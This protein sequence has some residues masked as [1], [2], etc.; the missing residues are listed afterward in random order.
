MARTH[1]LGFPRI[2]FERELKF[3]LEAFWRGDTDET[4]LRETGR[5]LR[6]RH[7]ELQRTAGLDQ[8]AAGDFAFYDTML[9]QTA[10]LGA[11]PAR[12]AFDA[13]ALTLAQYFELARGNARQPAM[14]MTKWF[15]T[16]YHYL[17]PELGPE[18]RF[19]GGTEWLFEEVTEALA[20]APHV[21]PVL[22]GPI[23]FLVLSKSVTAGFDRLQL[24]PALV[25]AYERILG[26]LRA[27]GVE[28]V[29]LDEPALCTDLEPAWL[30]AYDTAY[31]GLA[32]TGLKILLATYFGSAADRA[33]RISRLP[34]HGVHIDLMRDLVRAPQSLDVWQRALP[35]H[36]VLS[37]GVIDGRNVWRTN[38]RKTVSMLRPLHDA[39]GDRLW[40]APSCSLSHVPVSLASEIQLDAEVRPWLAFATEKL[41]EVRVIARALN[42][43]EAAVAEA[44]DQSDA[45][46]RSRT[47]SRR[48]TNA[49]V[50]A[51]VAGVTDRMTERDSPFKARIAKQR[52]ALALP[53][54]PTTTIGSF[55]QV[56]SLRATRAA[57]KRGEIGALDYLQH[58][59]SEIE[60]A[61]RKQEALGLDVLVHGEAERNDMVEYFAEH[62]WGYAITREGWVQS[63]GSRCVK[64]PIIYGDVCRPEPITV[65]TIAYAQS[66]TDK[67]VKG[68][69]TGP[70]TM[71]QWSFVRDD[72][73]RESVAMQIALAIRE[74]VS[75]LEKSGVRVIQIDE[76]ALREG[77]PLRRREWP[78]YLAWAVRAFRLAAAAVRDDTQIH[79]HMCYSEFGDILPAIAA[80][81]ADVITIETSRSKME[82]LEAFHAFSYPNDIG[83]GIYDIHSP[84]VPSIEDMLALLRRAADVIPLER[85]WV[86][87][88]CGL[89]TRGWKETEGALRN[90]VEA[91]RVLRA[92][93]E[94]NAR[95][96]ERSVAT[97]R[98]SQHASPVTHE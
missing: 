41:G 81:D 51:Q 52:A 31:R 66:L 82:L 79:T 55:P 87:P 17:V 1:I 76:P 59:R 18:T 49:H 35:E 44:L 36:M 85:L 57:Y 71:L 30:D 74:E 95:N 33:E 78:A 19:D 32:D 54:L 62:L 42:E 9:S 4:P 91:A 22:I 77:L 50:R 64:P 38:L 63:Y 70:I 21:K 69:L 29:Q 93:V 46:Q 8:I 98:Q 88:D 14:E 80:L 16:N 13:K 72:E 6:T 5:A 58:I 73:A 3:A 15:D 53:L 26:R 34:V 86:N 94:G 65:D 61:V 28:W 68:M 56:Q 25:R 27:L 60:S 84:R 10:L 40:I 39:C 11:V 89:K 97:T 2:G 24:L 37:A 83:P 47:T 23:T 96:P 43:G 20:L 12:F 90:M 45:A 67:P 7:C 75:D 48:V 92:E